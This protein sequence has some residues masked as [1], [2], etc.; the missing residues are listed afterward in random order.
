[1]QAT[2]INARFA[3]PLDI[4]AIHA[5][6]ERHPLVVTVE[7]HALAGGFSSA[8]GECLMDGGISARVLRLGLPDRFVEHGNRAE[9]LCRYGLGSAEI[10]E[11]AERE[12]RAVRQHG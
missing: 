4:E 12:L 3:K 11:R 6:A 8:V 10:A 2:V 7:D 9:L 5:A 1:M